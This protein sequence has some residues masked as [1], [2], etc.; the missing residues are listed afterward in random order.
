[1]IKFNNVNKWFKELHVL[2]DINL[3]VKKGEVVVVCGPSGS[4]KSTLIRTV[5][6]LEQI[7]SGEIWVDGVNVADPATDLNKI[8]A[9]VGFVFQHF[10]LYPHLSVLENIVLSPMKVKKQSRAQAEEKALQLLE[11]VGLAHKKDAMP[12]ELSGG[13]QQRVAIARGLAMEPQVMLFDEPTSALDPEMVGEVLKVMK[14][15]A[16][17]GMT[18]MCVTHEMGFA[19]EVSDRIIFVDQ[20]KIVEVDTP[21][22]FFT[23]PSS[24]RAKQFLNQV[25]KA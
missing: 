17:S 11:R 20:G 21:E 15:L 7:Q 3:E 22:A 1:M 9:E 4:G 16:E 25:M 14:D 24:E 19:R 8:R 5:N 12:G 18:M 2:S 13:Q 10:N 23:N 6:Q